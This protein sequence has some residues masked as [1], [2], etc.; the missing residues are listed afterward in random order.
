MSFVKFLLS[1]HFLWYVVLNISKTVAQTPI[2]DTI[3]YHF[4]MDISKLLRFKFLAEININ[5]QKIHYSW[6][7]KDYKSG[8]KKE[9]LLLFHL[10]VKLIFVFE[11]CQN[12]FSW[13]PP[14][15]PFWS[16]K[17]LNFGGESC[18][19]KILS[20][21]IQETCTLK[22]VKKQVLLF[23]SSWELNLSNLMVDKHFCAIRFL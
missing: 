6:Q 2:K 7:S 4:Q 19:I 1:Q 12:S 5:L 15:D 14:F 16:A 17:Y 21:S 8:R 3:F 11:K 13:S 18:E 22:K 23:L 9:N 20:C 10:F